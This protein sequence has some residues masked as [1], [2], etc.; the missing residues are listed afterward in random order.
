MND[1]RIHRNIKIALGKG[2]RKLSCC[3]SCGLPLNASERISEQALNSSRQCNFWGLLHCDDRRSPWWAR[4]AVVLTPWFVKI[5]KSYASLW[6]IDQ[7]KPLSAT[8]VL[9]LFTPS[10]R[11]STASS[12]SWFMAS[13]GSQFDYNFH[14][15][16][17]VLLRFWTRNY[18]RVFA[19]CELDNCTHLIDKLTEREN[20]ENS[21]SPFRFVF[22]DF[23]LC[24]CY[25]FVKYGAWHVYKL[26]FGSSVA[27][28]RPA[29]SK[30]LLLINKKKKSWREI[31]E[32]V[33]H[34]TN[35]QM[36]WQLYLSSVFCNLI[37]HA[38]S[39]N[40]STHYIRTLS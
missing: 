3:D 12:G 10:F 2:V 11:R 29:C 5:L 27:T 19:V 33:G 4:I 25:N 30:S 36:A 9:S 7:M 26:L 38:L 34:C 32:L 20:L 18:I 40:D 17:F 21:D 24:S 37:K 23:R 35:W 39:A 31:W 22:G 13:S 14:R 28:W 15:S 1:N 6:D 16:C 8:V